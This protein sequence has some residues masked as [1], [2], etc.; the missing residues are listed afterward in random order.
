V[1]EEEKKE[2]MSR[3]E[4]VAV[5]VVVGSRVQRRWHEGRETFMGKWGVGTLIDWG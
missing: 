1:E 5:V 3:K 2:K 4:V